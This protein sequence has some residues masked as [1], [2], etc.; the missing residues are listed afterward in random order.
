MA[1]CLGVCGR[2]WERSRVSFASHK[3]QMSGIPRGKRAVGTCV[4]WARSPVSEIPAPELPGLGRL[5]VQTCELILGDPQH[6]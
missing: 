6:C 2:S 5:A 3:P 4:R 1:L